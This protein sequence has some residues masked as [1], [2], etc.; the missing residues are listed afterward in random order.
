MIPA[1]VADHAVA[2]NAAVRSGDFGEFATTFAPD[3]VMRFVGVPA[4]PFAGREAIAAAYAAQ[5]P[6]DTLTVR[7]VSTEGDTDTVRFDWDRGGGGTMVVR[8]H[9]GLVADLT[10]SFDQG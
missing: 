7:S 1:R 10:V 8:W 3:A 2:F 9:D 4:G 6:D 5:P